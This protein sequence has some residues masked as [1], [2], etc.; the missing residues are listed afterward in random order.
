VDISVKSGSIEAVDA[1]AIVVNLF[2]GVTQPGGATAAVDRALHGAIV[3]LIVNGAMRGNLNETAIIHPRE[4]IPARRVVVVGLGPE[5]AFDFDAAR[6]AA[7]AAAR[8]ARDSG[9]R[10]LASIVHG[11]GQGRLPFAAV[12][13]AVVE[14]TLLGLYRYAAPGII[15][16]EDSERRVDALTIVEFDAAKL[17]ELEAGTLAGQAIGTGTCLARDLANQPANVLTPIALAAAAQR[18]AAEHHMTCQVL[19]REQMAELKMGSLLSVAQGASQPPRFIVL[20]YAPAESDAP[21][22]VLVGK[23]ITFDSGGISIKPHEGMERMRSDMAGAAAVLGAMHAIAAMRLPRRVVALVPAAENMPSG[24]ATHPGDIVTAMNGVSIEIVNTDAEGR[25]IL[26]DALA[27]TQRYMPAAVIDVATLT[28][29][30]TIALGHHMTG[31]YASDDSLWEA[32]QSAG[33][34][35]GEPMWR[36]PLAPIYDRQITTPFADVKNTGGRPGSSVT[37][38]RFLS[39]FVGA[40]PWAHLDIAGTNWWEQDLPYPKKPYYVR[41]NTGVGVGTLVGVLRTW[42]ID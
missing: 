38:A 10:T 14:G 25:L 6:Q 20:E 29:A 8:A 13:Q 41:G 35:A 16:R 34:A 33:E 5:A 3:A 37:A 39:K 27:Y 15:P 32:I 36:M 7:A 23:G 1:D 42:G 31:V 9:A 4:A 40:H 21:P 30:I 11:G 12:A 24:T 2:Q 28:G 22:M 26:A 19:D 17:P 18:L